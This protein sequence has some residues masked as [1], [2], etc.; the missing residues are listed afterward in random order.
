MYNYGP[1]YEPLPQKQL[2][3]KREISIVQLTGKEY[4]NK[5][6][7]ADLKISQRTVEK[8]KET[9]RKKLGVLSTV[10][11]IIYAMRHNLLVRAMALLLYDIPLY[12]LPAI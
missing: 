3:T 4:T 1:G 11:V 2:L 9:M 5:Q 10:G 8:H 7:A 6:I 12:D